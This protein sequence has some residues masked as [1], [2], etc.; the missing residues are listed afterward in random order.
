LLVLLN[1]Y[2]RFGKGRMVLLLCLLHS[3]QI[4]KLLLVLVTTKILTLAW[5]WS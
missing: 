5:S 3:L 2:N 1:T 4:G